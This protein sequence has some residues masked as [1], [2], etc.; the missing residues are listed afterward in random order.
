MRILG[1]SAPYHDA[2]ACLIENGVVVSAVEEERLI[3]SKK[4]WGKPPVY[5][6]KW[7]LE[8]SGLTLNDIDKVAYSWNRSKIRDSILSKYPTHLRVLFPESVFGPMDKRIEI[9]DVDH[10]LAHAASAFRLSGFESAA[11]IVVDGTAEEAGTSLYHGRPDGTIKLIR[12]WPASMSLG[13]LYEAA[14]QYAGFSKLQAG[15][16]MGLAAYGQGQPLPYVRLTE[17]GYEMDVPELPSFEHIT[18]FW[19]RRLIQDFGPANVRRYEYHLSDCSHQ[20]VTLHD[21]RMQNM[22]KCI[23]RTL[24]ET[25]FHLAKLA[26]ELTGEERL[27]MAGGVALNC[28]ANGKL[29]QKSLFK[30]IFIPGPADDTGSAIGAAAEVWFQETNQRLQPLGDL[31]LGPRFTPDSV[32]H[33]LDRWGIQYTTHNTVETVAQWIAEG[34]TGGWFSGGVEI[35]PRALGHR[36]ILANPALESMKDHLNKEVKKREPWRPYGSSMLVEYTKDVFKKHLHSPYMLFTL[37]VEQEQNRL[38]SALHVD[39][40]TRVQTVQE[41]AN[42]D[43]AYLLHNLKT[44]LGFPC[45]LNTSFNFSDEPIVC[46]P[47]EAVRSFFASPLDFLYLEGHLLWKDR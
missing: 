30:E 20:E 11:I 14:T 47:E 24:E 17:T 16:L 12:S 40:T 29:L 4:A 45:V 21:E 37:P 28:T 6:A 42:D 44:Y 15:K 31:G 22:A 18:Q 43:Y 19:V 35:G 9:I 41:G 27:C 1:L 7:C 13:L 5:A 38:I 25:I 3:R 10:H 26:R 33:L 39:G 8:N 46:R 2:A 32:K 23:Q 36:S 34:K